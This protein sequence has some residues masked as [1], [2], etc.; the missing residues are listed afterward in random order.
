PD[1]EYVEPVGPQ[2]YSESA[3]YDEATAKAGPEEMIPGL[4]A[5]I[6]GAEDKNLVSAGFFERGASVSVMGN[7]RGN[8]GYTTRTSASYS[9][10]V[11]TRDGSGSGWASAEGH[12][13]R[14]V[15]AVAVARVAIEKAVLSQKP[16]RIEPGKYTV[17]LEPA[18]VSD[19]V[20]QILY[21]FDARDAEEGRSLLT[22]KGGGTRLGEKMFSEKITMR[23]DPFDPRR[24]GMPWT[25]DSLPARK[26]TWIDK[27]VVSNLGYSRYWA[28]KKN[29]EPTPSP[30]SDLIFDGENNTLDDLITS[31]ERGLLVTRFW[32]IRDVNPQ[33]GQLTGL[34]RDGLFMVEKGKIAYPIMN[35]RWNESPANVLANVEMLSR[36]VL[37]GGNVVP[38]M[39]A[40]DF[41][42]TSVS[43][44]V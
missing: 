16:R 25:Y 26:M 38:G 5:A 23:G 3:S 24:P 22:K 35:L 43:D 11:R 15:D 33:T 40:H 18:A 14:D 9:A 8:F 6:A 30:G 7:K 2:A 20:T 4:K 19:M 17:I 27:G 12:R 34:T 44:A 13:M 29:A 10:T 21:S 31:T 42:F 1:P 36:P 41:N 32:Y 28:K 37:V 39:K